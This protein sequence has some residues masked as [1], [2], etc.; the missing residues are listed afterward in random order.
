MK[1]SDKILLTTLL[2]ILIIITGLI[3][4]SRIIIRNIPGRPTK[5]S[6]EE[7]ATKILDLRDFES[8]ETKGIWLL[9][10][11]QGDE[12]SVSIEYPESEA[13][14][15]NVGTWNSCLQLENDYKW[16]RRRSPF[17]AKVT[18][19]NLKSVRTED[20]ASVEILDFTCEE[21]DVRIKGAVEIDA[22][23]LIITDLTLRCDGAADADFKDSKV[24]NAK[25]NING[26]SRITLTMAGGKLGGSAH[27]ASSIVY[28]GDVSIQDIATAGAVSVRHR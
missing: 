2:T 18:M 27:G 9:K 24:V 6:D 14:E 15:I 8:I 25:V 12:F 3:I 23:N 16:D 20:G 10:I 22:R 5:Y 17:R 7:I 26:A 1:N 19:P 13:D 28:Y 4:S 11:V 21:L